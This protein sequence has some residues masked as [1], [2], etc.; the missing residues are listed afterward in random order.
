MSERLY[1]Y[2][3]VGP[4]DGLVLSHGLS[5]AEGLDGAERG[6]LDAP[7][8][9][10]PYRDIRAIVSRLP[11][12]AV[13]VT[14]ANVLRHEQVIESLMIRCALLPVRFGTV[15]AGEERLQALL[16]AS[17][18]DF[19]HS[20]AR[21]AG[22]VEMGVRVLGRDATCRVCTR[23]AAGIES[24]G[25]GHG[26][27]DRAGYRYLMARLAEHRLET[28]RQAEAECVAGMLDAAL[29]A[30]SVEVRR[31]LLL[32][33]SLPVSLAYLVPRES[34]AAFLAEVERLRTRL[35]QYSF[36]SSGPWPPYN[37]VGGPAGG[38]Q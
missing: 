8:Y 2:A 6:L 29:A 30:Y 11:A 7:V 31:S 34:V 38:A 13:E 36:L 25:P 5:E 26:G 28:A 18:E 12:G 9:A 32:T 24:D 35:S 33:P 10:L 4:G 16:A 15:L 1:L 14:A 37:F 20:L 21:V 19:T 27:A 3:I 17:Y 23:P 22:K